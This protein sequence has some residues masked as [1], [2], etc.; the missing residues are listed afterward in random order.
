MDLPL[1]LI[2][3]SILHWLKPKCSVWSSCT[4]LQII[5]CGSVDWFA[6]FLP[7]HTLSLVFINLNPS[8]FGAEPNVKCNDYCVW[9]PSEEEVNTGRSLER[10]NLWA[11]FWHFRRKQCHRGGQWWLLGVM[12][13]TP[14]GKPGQKQRM[15]VILSPGCIIK[16]REHSQ[17]SC[18]LC[19]SYPLRMT[20]TYS[21][22]ENQCW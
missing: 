8:L 18:M 17:P 15:V 5:F 22:M 9:N 3:S 1:I 12:F 11:G 6:T 2:K 7:C 14:V 4:V 19:L 16:V 21:D 13:H 10:S 20:A